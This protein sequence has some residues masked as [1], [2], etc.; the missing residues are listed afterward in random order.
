M[1]ASYKHACI[2]LRKDLHG[3]M[4]ITRIGLLARHDDKI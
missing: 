1:G 3:T 4:G 2:A